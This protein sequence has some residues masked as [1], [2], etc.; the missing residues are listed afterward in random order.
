MT[1]GRTL[2]FGDADGLLWL[3]EQVATR[4]GIGDVLAQGFLAAIEKFGL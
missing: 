1:D 3:I 2:G 4:Q